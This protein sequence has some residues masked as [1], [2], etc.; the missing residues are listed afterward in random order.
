MPRCF[1]FRSG[2]KAPRIAGLSGVCKGLLMNGILACRRSHALRGTVVV[3]SVVG[4]LLAGCSTLPSSGPTGA[5]VEKAA[6]SSVSELPFT[7][8]ELDAPAALPAPPSI[9]PANLPE[10][11]PQPTDLVGPGDILDI[12]IY[13]AGVTLFGGS[14][15]RA[16][17]TGSLTFDPSSNAEKLPPIR[18]DD[19]GF[20]KLP[21]VGRIRAAGHTVT[22]LESTIQSGLRGMSQD[23]QV[24]VSVEQSITESVTLAGEV[25]RP[26]RLVLNTSKETLNDVIA[27]AGGY[28]GAAKD[29][30]AIVERNDQTFQIRLSDLLGHPDRDLRIAPGDRITLV[31]RPESFMALGAPNKPDEIPFPR[32]HINLAEAISLAGGANPNVGDA[33]AI[34]VFRYTGQSDGSE[35]PVVYHLNMMKPG[36]YFLSQRFMMQ[37]GD[38]LYVG[39]A[40]ANQ[41]SKLVQLL[42]QLFLPIATVRNVIP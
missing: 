34:F 17:A 21:F 1:P 32:G 4:V 40:R 9:V 33:A 16:A 10:S 24:L 35:K 12:T 3:V 31:S 22:E 27:L 30:V 39:N 7:V 15:L 5:E 6:R 23:P 37:D 29:T 41:P 38:V 13:E 8:V 14:T 2:D 36:A 28:K 42:S 26:G 19:Y 20:I 18:V 25:S 11:L